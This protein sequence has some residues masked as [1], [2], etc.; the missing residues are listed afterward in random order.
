MRILY[1]RKNNKETKY[2]IKMVKY[3]K[4]VRGSLILL[5]ICMVLHCIIGIINPVINAN[6]LT[7]ITD[8]K[9]NESFKIALLFVIV[10][11]AK[12]FINYFTDYLI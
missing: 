10:S 2:G 12:A 4:T 3:F 9:V 1:M 7:S 8:F 5:L 6:L 11:F